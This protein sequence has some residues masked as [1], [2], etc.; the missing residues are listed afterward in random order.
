MLLWRGIRVVPFRGGLCHCRRS[1]LE[2]EEG[3]HGVG[4]KGVHEVGGRGFGD[5]GWTEEEGGCD[6]DVESSEK[7]L[8]T[9]RNDV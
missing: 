1:V 4:G 2:G 3:R 6:P 7:G 5:A 9:G 8:G